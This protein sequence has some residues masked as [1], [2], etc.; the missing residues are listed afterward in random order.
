[1]KKYLFVAGTLLMV[2]VLGVFLSNNTPV[3]EGS[4][5]IGSGYTYKVASSSNA[6]A[7]V[8]YVIRGGSGI[9]GSI[10]IG[11]STPALVGGTPVRIYDNAL[12]TSTATSTLI[13]SIRPG[14]TEQ[15][16]TFDVN[17]LRGIV[18]D[19]PVG[20]NGVYTVTYR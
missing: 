14:V 2:F 11:S 10:I 8:P 4:V 1:M 9:L 18:L 15:T 12:G 20:F 7:T 6:S 16:I 19:I 17:V 13:G 3:A 5:S